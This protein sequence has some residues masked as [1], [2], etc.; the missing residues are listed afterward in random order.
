MDMEIKDNLDMQVWED[1][2]VDE[3]TARVL[4]RKVAQYL[5][6]TYNVCLGLLDTYGYEVYLGETPLFHYTGVQV[7][8]KQGLVIFQPEMEY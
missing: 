8:D 6:D 2:A 7:F 5:L 4:A 1:A 3:E